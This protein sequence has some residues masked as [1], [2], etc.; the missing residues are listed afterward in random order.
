MATIDDA[1]EQMLQEAKEQSARE[2]EDG[3]PEGACTYG[4]PSG[5]Q[6]CV[7]LTKSACAVIK[8][9]VY[10]GDGTKCK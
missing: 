1:F 9:S 4:L 2:V 6:I 10:L 3:E 8:G 5:Q 7:S